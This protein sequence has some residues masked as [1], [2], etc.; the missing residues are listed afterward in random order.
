MDVVTAS[1]EVQT[2]GFGD[3]V[4]ITS[5]VNTELLHS[6]IRDGIVTVF[7]S[8]STAAVTTIEYESGVVRDLQSAFDRMIPM[9]IPYKH[10]Q[11]WQ[12]GNGFSHVRSALLGPSITIPVQEGNMMLG[13]WQQLVLVDFD[14]SHRQRSLILQIIGQ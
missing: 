14:N 6:G 4:D 9:D 10:D 3:T 12:D 1:I 11:R 13:T 5:D 8:G 2:S 7:V